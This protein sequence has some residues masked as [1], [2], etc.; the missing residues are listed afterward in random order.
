MDLAQ[1]GLLVG[2]GVLAGGINS[3]AGGGSLVS[4]PALL[5]AGYPGVVANVTNIRPLRNP[6]EQ[7]TALANSSFGGPHSGG[8]M[9]VFGDGSVRFLSLNIDLMALTYLAA[10]QDGQVIPNY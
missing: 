2:A 1:F 6:N 5:A 7:T 10:R 3:V 8:C 9:F 4:F